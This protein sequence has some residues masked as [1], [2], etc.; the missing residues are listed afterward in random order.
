M[1]SSYNYCGFVDLYKSLSQQRPVRSGT[2]AAAPTSARAT[3]LPDDTPARPNGTAER[4]LRL[5]S[6]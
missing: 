6:G 3:P 1:H 5:V 4:R 2:A